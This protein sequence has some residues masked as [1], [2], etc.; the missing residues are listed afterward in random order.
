MKRSSLLALI[1]ALL[2][3]LPA[4]GQPAAAPTEAAPAA[5]P[6]EASAAPTAEPVETGPA[7]DNTGLYLLSDT[8]EAIIDDVDL[9]RYAETEDNARVFY[10]I[11]VGS[12]SD[13]NGDGIGDL[14]GII[15][16][17]D[18]LNDGDPAS[19]LSLGVEG[20]WL[21]PIFDSPSYHKYDVTDYYTVDPDFGTMEDLKELADLCE[22]RNVKLILDLPIN[23]TGRRNA[24][25][26]A[27]V[28]AHRN[29]DEADPYYNFYCW[30]GPGESAPA[31][32]H[33]APVSGTEDY[34]ECNFDSAMPELDF[35]SELVR[36]T[37]LD[38]AKFY[39]DL[40]VDGFRFDAAK[41][42]YYGDNGSSAA[43]W[44][45]YMEELR[46]IDPEIYVV[47]EVWDGDGVTDKYYGSMNCF[48]FTL[49][50]SGGLID[51][52][53]KAGSAGRYASYV[54]SYLNTVRALRSDAMLVPFVSNHDMDRAS[55]YLQSANYQMQMAA[56]LYI[57]GP[58]SPFLY[59]GEEIGMRGSRGGSNTDANRR[60]AMR[61][62]D[63]DTVRDPEGSTYPDQEEIS[64]QAQL[65]RGRSLYNYYKRLILIRRANPEIARGTY[66]AVSVPDSKVGGFVSTWEG[67]AVCVLH[68]PSQGAK[69]IDLAALGLDFDTIAACIGAG[70]ATL[71]GSSLRLEGQT[72]VV[73]R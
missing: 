9:S 37:V 11:F 20:L 66:T 65:D 18:Y 10:E 5:E 54:E 62:G 45:W 47:A 67:S 56:N 64:V 24:W 42:V 28:N 70:E 49:A 25:F 30:Y 55:G 36:Q 39:L 16:R 43:F 21:T 17:F 60:L 4:C 44:D 51:E 29:K 27:F 63:G 32:R 8:G 68:N 72:S 34:Y 19:G 61:W 31:G 33:Y 12:F 2:F 22:S 46:K 48:N 26:S 59:Y 15:D 69:T 73:L 14:R 13:S 1:L 35:D 3:L 57:L 7:R 40:G 6:A 53:A 38:V 71:E 23:H 50:Q 41:Y 58:G 52:T